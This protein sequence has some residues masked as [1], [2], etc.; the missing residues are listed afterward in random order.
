MARAACSAACLLTW[1]SGCLAVFAGGS[2]SWLSQTHKPTRTNTPSYA[3]THSHTP[4]KTQS[5]LSHTTNIQTQKPTLTHSHTL[6]HT[7]LKHEVSPQKKGHR[8]HRIPLLKNN[9]LN[10][11]WCPE[12][13]EHIPTP[14][15]A[16]KF[17]KLN[18]GPLIIKTSGGFLY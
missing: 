11:F 18:R 13:G 7:T 4:S 12:E 10:C 16:L 2:G 5:P 17:R 14:N 6:K 3:Q 8:F 1:K 15:D 9:Q